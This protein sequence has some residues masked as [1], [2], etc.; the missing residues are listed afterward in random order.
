MKTIGVL[1]RAWPAICTSAACGESSSLALRPTFAFTTPR[2]TRAGL[3]SRP[4]LSRPD[5]GPSIWRDRSTP[6]GPQWLQPASSV[7]TILLRSDR[8]AVRVVRFGIPPTATGAP[9][10]APL[11][12]VRW[13]HHLTGRGIRHVGF[14][15][16]HLR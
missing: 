9:D 6:P 3:A 1:P 16:R 13:G 2:W 5:A 10:F 4:W 11:A 14:Y 15:P 8:D 7:S 12:R